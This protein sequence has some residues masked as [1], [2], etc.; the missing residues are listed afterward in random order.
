MKVRLKTL[1]EMFQEGLTLAVKPD[2]VTCKNKE[3]FYSDDDSQTAQKTQEFYETEC[4]GSSSY[5][6]VSC[7]GSRTGMWAKWA[8][9]VKEEVAVDTGSTKEDLIVAHSNGWTTRTKGKK[10]F[11]TQGQGNEF[12]VA[13]PSRHMTHE[14]VEHEL[15]YKY[16]ILPF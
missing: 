16:V 15:G 13:A 14:E 8:C 1:D 11:A 12:E 6:S 9:E 2:R 10:L 7:P 3:G 4:L 5:Y